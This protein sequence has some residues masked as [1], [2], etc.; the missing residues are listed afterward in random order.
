LLPLLFSFALEYVI[1]R[2]QGNH[3]KLKLKR[4]YQLLV[5]ADDFNLL[6]QNLNTV[7][8]KTKV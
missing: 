6:N 7:E 1:G 5:G 3:E 4:R 2:I 8:K